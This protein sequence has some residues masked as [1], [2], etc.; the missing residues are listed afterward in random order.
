MSAINLRPAPCHPKADPRDRMADPRDRMADPRDRMADPGNRIRQLREVMAEK[1]PRAEVKPAGVFPTGLKMID[2]AEGGLRRGAVTELV[3]PVSGGSLLIS[4]LLLRLEEEGTFGGLVDAG[5]TFD[6]QGAEVLRRLLWVRAPEILDAVKATD[7]LLRDGNLSLVLLDVQDLALREVR[8][9]PASTWHRF[10]RLIEPSGTA[11]VI[12][13]TQPLVEG[14]RV[15]IAMRQRWTLEAMRQRR[16][17]L[18]SAV[19]AQ[20]FT[21]RH[22]AQLPVRRQRQA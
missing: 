16:S 6:P 1:F 3:G 15:R 10:Q 14:A 18:L 12:L 4:A 11:F 13:S 2:E 21:R 17:K 20:V 8:R 22:F 9:V 19:E 5:G 7:L